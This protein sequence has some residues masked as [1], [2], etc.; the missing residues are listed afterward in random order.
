MSSTEGLRDLKESA[1]D[2]LLKIYPVDLNKPPPTLATC[3]EAS[4]HHAQYTQDR[5]RRM[6]YK[7]RVDYVVGKFF[8]IIQ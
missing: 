8:K 4:K 5:W 7:I 6:Q 2:R 3:A 1:Y